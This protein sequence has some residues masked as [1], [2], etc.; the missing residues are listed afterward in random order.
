MQKISRFLYWLYRLVF[1]RIFCWK[2]RNER[3]DD[4]RRYI[5]TINHPE[6]CS[7]AM[8]LY[9]RVRHICDHYLIRL[10]KIDVNNR[11]GIPIVTIT[12]LYAAA[13]ESLK[14]GRPKDEKAAKEAA[15]FR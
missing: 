14:I 8:D 1:I 2:R 15:A 10:G 9:E 4:V 12:D 5:G 7:W 6:G 11:H 13:A 3:I